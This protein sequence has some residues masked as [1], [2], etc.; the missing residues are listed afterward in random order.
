VE[1]GKE[2]EHT[3]LP[4]NIYLE[5][6]VSYGLLGFAAFLAFGWC[7]YRD[8]SLAERLGDPLERNVAVSLKAGLVAFAVSG[9]WGHILTMKILWILAGLAAALRR[10]VLERR[11]HE[12]VAGAD[13][14]DARARDY[15]TA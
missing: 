7:A 3:I 8:L 15:V 1:A 12:S 2:S 11:Q 13:S 14:P 6:A 5:V 4:H 9:I 10:V